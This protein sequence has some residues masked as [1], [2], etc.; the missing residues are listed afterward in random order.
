R[1]AVVDA[2][3]AIAGELGT[4]AVRVSLAWLLR[5]A[6]S[7]STALVPIVGPR[8]PAQLEEYLGSLDL[9]LDDEHHRHLD[10]VSAIL[11]GTP[12]EDVT[13]ALS[14]GVDGD[15]TL[16]DPVLVPAT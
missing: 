1:T 16:L 15:R 6:A 13:A 8:T 9:D 5:R 12:H 3:L 10:E 11:L 7:A 4:S 2:V 14:H